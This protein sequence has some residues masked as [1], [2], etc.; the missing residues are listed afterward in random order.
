V[1]KKCVTCKKKFDAARKNA[2]FCSVRCYRKSPA[3]KEWQK[4]YDASPAKLKY[5]YSEIGRASYRRN[6]SKKQILIALERLGVVPQSKDPRILYRELKMAVHADKDK[7]RKILRGG[8]P[9]A[10]YGRVE[11]KFGIDVLRADQLILNFLDG[12]CSKVRWLASYDSLEKILA[13]GTNDSLLFDSY[14][15]F[16][17]WC[18]DARKL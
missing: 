3:A 14:Y 11:F 6:S 18:Q 2:R 9:D 12:D 1:L 13:G 16:V 5:W 8:I 4:E 15:E 10:R 7:S 17:V